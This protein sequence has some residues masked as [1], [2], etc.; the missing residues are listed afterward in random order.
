MTSR[1]ALH[2]PRAEAAGAATTVG[3]AL[4]V[5]TVGY[6]IWLAE[7]LGAG[8]VGRAIATLAAAAI[9]TAL[10]PGTVDNAALF[11]QA[12]AVAEESR[13]AISA[14][15]TAAVTATLLAHAIGL[16]GAQALAI[17]KKTGVTGAAT[18][19]APV[20]SALFAG[21]IGK[22]GARSVGAGEARVTVAATTAA[23]I[24][25]ALFAGAIG[26]TAAHRAAI[27]L[28]LSG[29]EAIPG[30]VT[31]ERIKGADAGLD[32]FYVTPGR[33]VAAT[34][35]PV[36]RATFI[37]LAGTD[38]VPNVVATEIIH[39]ADTGF[40]RGIGAAGSFVGHAAGA[41]FGTSA[42]VDGTAG[43]VFAK[44][45]LT[46]AIAAAKTAVVWT[47]IAGLAKAGL[48]DAVTAAIAAVAR[49]TA[50]IFGAVARPIAADGQGL[51]VADIGCRIGA[52]AI[53]LVAA[54]IRVIGT[55]DGFA[56]FVI[57]A[58]GAVAGA[59]IAGA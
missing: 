46:I 39:G 14:T 6:A 2:A 1:R 58:G 17:A 34:A 24:I 42:T 16:A 47:T 53:P 48:T 57:A 7:E 35:I 40:H 23:P 51:A 59:T 4:F 9:V 25:P 13:G 27:L 49:A 19:A 41:L 18:A 20:G 21:A 36:A 38:G 11:A 33:A 50:A 12:I 15:P 37:G 3:A 44:G 45:P 28:G 54:A 56:G 32:V 10:L 52:G 29:A 43:T 31:A 22:T 55:D 26:E 8:E 30:I 5:V